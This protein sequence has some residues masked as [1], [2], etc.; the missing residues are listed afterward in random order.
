MLLRRRA[1]LHRAAGEALETLTRTGPRRP[2]D[3]VS[4]GRHFGLGGIPER[5]AEFLI[6][7]GDWARAVY[8][9]DDALKHY[10]AALEFL[11]P[12]PGTEMARLRIKER[13]ADL[14]A[15]A[16]RRGEA[17][18]LYET[19]YAAYAAAG[20]RPEQARLCRKIAAL[21]WDAGERERA[22]ERCRAGLALLENGPRHIEVAH[23]FEELGRLAFRTG[24][25]SEAAR[26]A[27]QA[28]A[29]VEK[30]IG[31]GVPHYDGAPDPGWRREAAQI[32]SHAQN[33]L[34]VALARQRRTADAVA[35][36]ERSVEVAENH[37][38][39]DA[40]LRGYSNLGVLY[41]TL[42]PQRAIDSCR[43]G[44]E[45][46][47][48]IGDLGFEARLYANLAVAC[49]TFTDRCEED[50]RAAAERALDLDRRLDLRDH[51][52]VPLTVLAQIHQCHGEPGKALKYYAEALE[53]ASEIGEAQ[54]LFPCYDGL[55]VLY[56]DRGDETRAEEYFRKAQG[57]CER[58]GVEPDAL[59]VLPFL[60]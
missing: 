28:L 27:E 10:R 8:A 16:G 49:C 35:C 44:L 34:G 20:D 47:R 7:A 48:R 11:E 6:Q 55:A 42:E 23:H 25:F 38:L 22:L 2:E 12:V 15:P 46:A 17:L 18:D 50:G 41:S 36:V 54:L 24:D 31:E 26:W 51:L 21:L 40:A 4:L 43:K 30:M 33:T 60:E 29:Y 13:L 9:N 45:V 59:V 19:A 56:L 39:L 32:V 1:A 5:G 57:V 3:L 14:L 52:A 53:I 58:A 37:G